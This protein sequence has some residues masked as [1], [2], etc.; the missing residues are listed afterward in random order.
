LALRFRRSVILVLAVILTAVVLL[1]LRER[2]LQF[3]G[4]FLI[5]SERPKAAD[6]I[7]V[8]GGDFYGAR[9]DRAAD[10]V[11]QGYAPRV[12]ISG[13]PYGTPPRPEGEWAI[14][15]LA[16]NGYRADLFV[17]FG[18]AAAST[19]DEI[20]ALCG[21]LKRRHAQRILLVTDRYHSRRSAFTFALICPEISVRS[22]PASDEKFNPRDWWTREKD[23]ALVR[24]E[25]KKI[26]GTV[27]LTPRYWITRGL[28]H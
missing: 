9:V 2:V 27:A 20:L 4:D 10:L 1:L 26:L 18:H 23:A 19:P 28:A 25:W 12:L 24:S 6:L 13:P 14:E 16:K 8:L 17:S 15:R 7:V 21:E 22:V 11:T 5:A 3:G